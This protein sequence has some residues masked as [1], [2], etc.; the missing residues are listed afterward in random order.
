MDLSFITAELLNDI[1]WVDGIIYILL[2]IGIYI[3]IR[4]INTKIK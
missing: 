3:T 1:S 4:Y 2:G